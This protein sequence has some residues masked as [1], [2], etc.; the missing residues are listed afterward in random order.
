MSK[1]AAVG[2]TVCALVREREREREY[3]F[4]KN[5]KYNIV[6]QY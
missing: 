1:M 4:A 3:L 6:V 5:I 2:K